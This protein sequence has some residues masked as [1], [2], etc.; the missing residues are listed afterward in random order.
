[1]ADVATLSFGQ[2]ADWAEMYVRLGWI[3]LRPGPQPTSDP[4]RRANPELPHHSRRQSK[5][6]DAGNLAIG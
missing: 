6:L 5:L 1:M 4:E 3:V 2:Y